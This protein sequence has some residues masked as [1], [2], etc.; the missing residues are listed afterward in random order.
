[1]GLTSAVFLLCVFLGV[2]VELGV[3]EFVDVAVKLPL[4]L[5]GLLQLAFLP[6][7]ADKG[8]QLGDV[9]VRRGV[10]ELRER[11]VV[12]NELFAEGLATVQKG[13]GSAGFA[14]GTVDGFTNGDGIEVPHFF[15]DQLE[16]TAL[17][18]EGAHLSELL[19]FHE[20]LFRKTDLVQSFI[21]E[22][23]HLFS[24]ILKFILNAFELGFGRAELFVFH[25]VVVVLCHFE[26]SGLWI[27]GDFTMNDGLV[28]HWTEIGRD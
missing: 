22:L 21:S 25:V 27:H 2:E 3:E 7:I 23:G 14:G 18:T 9:D 1:M 8:A 6:C 26:E 17:S 16:L 10:D 11:F 24:E 20:D 4:T 5:G 15:A 12:F 19:D 13:D 28:M